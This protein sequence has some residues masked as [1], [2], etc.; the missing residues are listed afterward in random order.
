MKLPLPT[1]QQLFAKL[2]NLAAF[3]GFLFLP[4]W[5]RSDN[6]DVREKLTNV[7]MPI[8]IENAVLRE[9]PV[10]ERADVEKK[11]CET[12][13]ESLVVGRGPWGFGYLSELPNCVAVEKANA[14]SGGAVWTLQ[15]TSVAPREIS[16]QVC[17]DSKL[18]KSGDE[19]CM[20]AVKFPAEKNIARMLGEP[21]FVRTIV[22]ALMD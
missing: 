7:E 19:L 18:A 15:V 5:A 8:Q 21:Y 16:V 10:A 1:F 22:A 20:A 13:G 11:I 4:Q 12:F 6:S 14:L 2:L 3:V 17:R 9:I